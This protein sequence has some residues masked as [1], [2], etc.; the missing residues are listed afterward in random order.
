MKSLEAK[1][2]S[3]TNLDLIEERQTIEAGVKSK[4]KQVPWKLMRK[5]REQDVLENRKRLEKQLT[6]KIKKIRTKFD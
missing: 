1:G 6:D 2:T 4:T 5:L 3:L